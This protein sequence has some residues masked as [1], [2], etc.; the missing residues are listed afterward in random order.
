MARPSP[1][2][3]AAFEAS[4]GGKRIGGPRAAGGVACSLLRHAAAEA[5]IQARRWCARPAIL[6]R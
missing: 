2:G 5:D 1:L 6:N 3:G 4:S